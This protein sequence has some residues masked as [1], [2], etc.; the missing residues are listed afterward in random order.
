MPTEPIDDKK[1]GYVEETD[2]SKV[3]PDETVD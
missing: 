1:T 2:G 3:V